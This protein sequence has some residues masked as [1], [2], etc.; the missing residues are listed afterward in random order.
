[1]KT[2]RQDT[3]RA[4]GGKIVPL[5][6]CMWGTARQLWKMILKLFCE[7]KCQVWIH[8]YHLGGCTGRLSQMGKYFARE[9]E[10]NNTQR[11]RREKHISTKCFHFTCSVS[12]TIK[13]FNTCNFAC[14]NESGNFRVIYIQISK[15]YFVYAGKIVYKFL[16]I[17]AIIE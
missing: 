13:E 9:L 7:V 8:R 2:L 17:I 6:E 16:I 5:G 11:L 14:K 10:L 3:C 15:D 1:M 4:A 12:G